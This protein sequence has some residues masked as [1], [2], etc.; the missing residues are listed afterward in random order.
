MSKRTAYILIAL[1]FAA[2]NVVG[3]LGYVWV[4]GGS[5]EPSQPV[6]APTLSLP[7]AQSD[8]TA[9]PEIT[10]EAAAVDTAASDKVL[11]RIVK[12]ESEVRFNIYEEL[13]GVPTT[14][15]GRTREVAGDFIVDFGIPSASEAGTIVINA[16]TLVTD[17]E[18]RNRAIRSEILESARAE[19]EF[20]NFKPTALS[21]LPASVPSTGTVS[22]Q[23]S[24]DLTIRTITQPVTFNVTLNTVSRER[25]QGTATAIVTRSQY[26]LQIPSVPSVANVGEEVTLEIDFTAAAVE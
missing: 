21:G 10:P 16:R 14:V 6:S 22:F 24:G 15:V 25:L 3:V 9:E 8:V 23:I 18:F 4:I 19:Y 1:A 5:G 7:S 12:E 11:F 2:G 26:N 13:R 17:N 20:V